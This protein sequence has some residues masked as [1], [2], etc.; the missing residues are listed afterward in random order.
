MKNLKK[1]N[2]VFDI[3]YGHSLELNRMTLTDSERGIAFVSRKARD[4]G[5]SAF[6]KPVKGLPPAIAGELT[7]ALGGQGGALSTFLQERPFYTGRDVS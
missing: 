4:N 1:L 5:V 6:V 2:E 3:R 7:V